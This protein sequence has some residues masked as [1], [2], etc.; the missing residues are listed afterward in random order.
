MQTQL[1]DVE[2]QTYGKLH[3]HT[4]ELQA[5]FVNVMQSAVTEQE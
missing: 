3:E 5:K 1:K 2:F 4:P